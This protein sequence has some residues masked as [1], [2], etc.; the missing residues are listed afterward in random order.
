MNVACLRLTFLKLILS[1][2]LFVHVTDDSS[3][4]AGQSS[5]DDEEL[6]PEAD[7]LSSKG[8][9]LF[10]LETILSLTTFH[11]ANRTQRLSNGC[12]NMLSLV[13]M[14]LTLACHLIS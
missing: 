7:Q 4:E 2:S 1:L 9:L 10:Y 12:E 6:E 3:P 8:E 11:S 14:L 5:S 13:C